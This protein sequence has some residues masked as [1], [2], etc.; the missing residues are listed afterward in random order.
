MYGNE[1]KSNGP[2]CGNCDVARALMKITN[3]HIKC[4]GRN[5]HEKYKCNYC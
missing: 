1:W 3:C 2:G 5:L 4:S